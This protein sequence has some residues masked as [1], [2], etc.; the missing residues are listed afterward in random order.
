MLQK[1]TSME[2]II[3]LIQMFIDLNLAQKFDNHDKLNN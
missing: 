2:K 3:V 1:I